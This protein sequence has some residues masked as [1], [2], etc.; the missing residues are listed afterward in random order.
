MLGEMRINIFQEQLN[1]IFEVV[2]AACSLTLVK[3]GIHAQTEKHEA[4][5]LFFDGPASPFLPQSTYTLR[6]AALGDADMFLVPVGRKGD[7]F[8]YEAVFNYVF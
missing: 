6:Q 8:Q 3:I 5:S 4:F 2:G 1:T 7:G